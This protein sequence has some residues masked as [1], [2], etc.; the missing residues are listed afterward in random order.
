MA[1]PAVEQSGAYAIS[2]QWAKRRSRGNSHSRRG[3]RLSAATIILALC[4]CSDKGATT[5]D[6]KVA[7]LESRL[8]ILQSSFNDLRDQVRSMSDHQSAELAPGQD[9]FAYLSD[10]TI[11]ITISLT[12]LEQSGSGVKAK[13][14][15]G[16]LTGGSLEKCWSYIHVRKTKDGPF[17]D[18]GIRYFEGALK[19]GTFNNT[20]TLIPDVKVED[21][22]ALRLSSLLCERVVL[23]V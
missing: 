23:N 11:A 1:D 18:G 10:G 5:T 12:K 6:G 4:G 3:R 15:I 21:I 9:G 17:E 20:S 16:N 8:D 22:S 19:P 2:S 13:V 14:Q 7:S